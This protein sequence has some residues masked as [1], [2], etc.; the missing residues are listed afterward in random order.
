MGM[1]R[2][3]PL[4]LLAF[5]S[6]LALACMGTTGASP[7]PGSSATPGAS[8]TPSPSPSPSADANVAIVRIET[9]GGFMPPQFILRRYPELV[10]YADGRLITQGPQIDLYPGPA[11]PSLVLTQLTQRGIEQVLEWARQA[12]L[13][14]PDRM[15]GQ[16]I[17]DAGF[18][19]FTIVYPD[20]AHTTSLSPGMGEGVPDPAIGALQQFEQV[21]LNV[22]TW[23]PDD[24]IGDDAAYASDRMWIIANPADPQNMP[25]PQLSTTRDWPLGALAAIGQPMSFG[26]DYRCAVIE[27]DDLQ[28]LQ[29][30][31]GDAN[32]LTLW[33]SEDALY[34][35]LFHPMLPDDEGCPAF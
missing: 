25:D 9:V 13:V 14:G 27:G 3:Q 16:M 6:F 21:L 19:N 7:T 8:A 4:V 15:L 35:V 34:Q 31:L 18:T 26:D 24:V 28:T 32:E 1:H 17:P 5:V 20:G 10:L 11:L 30:L 2:L 29:A 22:R 33:Q 23:L 12:G